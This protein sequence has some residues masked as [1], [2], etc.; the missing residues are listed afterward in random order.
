MALINA[1]QS[2]FPFTKINGCLFHWKQ[3]ICRKLVILKFKNDKEIL[4]N[5]MHINSMDILTAILENK[6]EMKGIP[7]FE[8]QPQ[9]CSI[10]RSRKYKKGDFWKYLKKN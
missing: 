4:E 3:A 8:R 1:V 10:G 7:F 5:C 9:R 6:I 2:I